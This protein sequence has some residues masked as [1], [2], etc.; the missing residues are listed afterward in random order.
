MA[1]KFNFTE[2]D[3]DLEESD[4]Q[5]QN[6]LETSLGDLQLKEDECDKIPCQEYDIM[7]SPLPNVIQADIL[8][9]PN[10]TLPL[11]KRTLADVKF[12]M[13][14]QD[15]LGDT[16][17]TTEENKVLDMLNLTGNSDLVRGVYEGGFKT[18]E[19]SVDLVQWLSTLQDIEGKRILEIGCGS[20]LPSLYL[21]A[22]Y[23]EVQVDVQDY[24]DQ[25]IR[26]ITLPN[27]LLNTVLSPQEPTTIEAN[28]DTDDDDDDD[29]D[30][31][32]N[33]KTGN[34]ENHDEDDEVEG[35]D[36]VMED[37][38]TC[39]AEAEIPSDKV[40]D[41][42]Q[43]VQQRT[44]A[45]VGD[46]AGLPNQLAQQKYDILITSETIYSEHSLP[47]LIRVFQNALHKPNGVGW[48]RNFTFL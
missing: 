20:A 11:Y 9:I 45:F 38:V 14:E 26:L 47:D 18:W 46:W 8:Q 29:D 24:N 16:N 3:L 41:M 15:T 6:D 32:E 13:A 33:N 23:Q 37:P 12:Q 43:Q 1:F 28:N 48:W 40:S 31:E 2:D 4:T 39:D 22:R 42:L 19:C 10:V 35:K 27:I 5:Q 44:K 21:L 30:D 34:D 25:V 36:Q 7:T 17:N